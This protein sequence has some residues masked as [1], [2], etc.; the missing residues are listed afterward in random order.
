MYNNYKLIKNILSV[1]NN[2]QIEVLPIVPYLLKFSNMPT[3]NAIN[4]RQNP[5]GCINQVGDHSTSSK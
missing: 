3:L 1:N 4:L 5:L 2:K